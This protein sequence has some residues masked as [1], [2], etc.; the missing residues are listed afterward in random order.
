MTHKDYSFFDQDLI[1]MNR[2]II[3]VRFHFLLYDHQT[4]PLILEKAGIKYDS[5]LGFAEQFGFRNSFCFPFQPYDIRNDKPYDFYE[6]PLVLMDGTLQKYMSRSPLEAMNNITD[7][8]LEIKKFNGCFTL[9]WHNTHFSEY[10]YAG[11]KE[12]FVQI[13]ELCKNEN[14]LFLTCSDLVNKFKDG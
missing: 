1:R 11:W 6:I 13:N 3:G 12:V 5:T 4:T 9:L 8:I 7:L 10:K 14:S 2:H